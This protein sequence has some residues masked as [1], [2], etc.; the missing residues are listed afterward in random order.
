MSPTPPSLPILAYPRLSV[1]NSFPQPSTR[2]LWAKSPITLA[3]WGRLRTKTDAILRRLIMVDEIVHVIQ[4]I[5]GLGI[6]T[7]PQEREVDITN[8]Y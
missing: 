2:A 4:E 5:T 8:L 7:V 1:V 3:G 6:V